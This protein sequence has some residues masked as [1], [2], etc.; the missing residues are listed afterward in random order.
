MHSGIQAFE[1]LM[2]DDELYFNKEKAAM[3]NLSENTD[4][5][6]TT[7]HILNCN[8]GGTTCEDVT[9]EIHQPIEHQPIEQLELTV[10]SPTLEIVGL[11]TMKKK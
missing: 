7:Q 5:Q 11:V 1:L 4:I 9:T 2:E 8:T 6:P 3:T 10:S